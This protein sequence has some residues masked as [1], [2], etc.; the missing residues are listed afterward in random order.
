MN[1]AVEKVLLENGQ[2]PENSVQYRFLPVSG[3]FAEDQVIFDRDRVNDTIDYANVRQL[4]FLP[5][6]E[7]N[8]VMHAEIALRTGFIY[9]QGR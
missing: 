7:Y 5:V 6:E 1:T 4:F 9:C 2:T 8:R 3:Y